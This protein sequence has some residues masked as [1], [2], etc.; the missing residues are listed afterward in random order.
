MREREPIAGHVQM[1]VINPRAPRYPEVGWVVDVL[2]E[3]DDQQEMI[4]LQL[5]FEAGS[6]LPTSILNL[7]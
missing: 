4:V 1:R 5:Q 3:K 6:R 2:R 7:N